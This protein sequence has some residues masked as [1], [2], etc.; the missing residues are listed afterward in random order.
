[1]WAAIGRHSLG[2]GSK[3]PTKINRSLLEH[4]GGDLMPPPKAGYLLGDGAVWGYDEDAAGGLAALP[5]VERVDQVNPDHGTALCG[6]IFSAARASVTS[7][8]HWL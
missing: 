1:M 4:L 3:R 7:C 8:R 6:S 5:G 2:V